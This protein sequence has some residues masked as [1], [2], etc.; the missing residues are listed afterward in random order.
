[1]IHAL[2]L[3]V[4]QWLGPLLVAIVSIVFFSMGPV[5]NEWLAYDRY[6]LEGF[7]TW[8]L[9]S[10]NFVHTNGYHLLLNLSGLA[11]LWALH[12]DHYSII[13][14]LKVIIWCGIATSTGI[15]LFSSSMIWYVGLSGALHG[16]FAWGAC[17]DI[18]SGLKSGW[19]LLIGGGIKIAYEQFY[20]SSEE[21]ANLIEASV[22]VD[23]HYYGAFAGIALFLLMWIFSRRIEQSGNSR[24]N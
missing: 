6:A 23:A 11:L 7:E 20:G 17:M 4:S 5:A 21:V 19:L 10:A 12:G 13:R 18:R 9:V 3:S 8:R 16:L 15:Y 24:A 22:A 1:M 14:F 2:P